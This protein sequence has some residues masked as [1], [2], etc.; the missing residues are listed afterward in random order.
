MKGYC[1]RVKGNLAY[2]GEERIMKI[3]SEIDCS[4]VTS[5]EL[6]PFFI[7]MGE[8]LHRLAKDWDLPSPSVP[9]LHSD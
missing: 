4:S 8:M 7:E 1:H 3:V 6:A 9:P 2:L 5:D